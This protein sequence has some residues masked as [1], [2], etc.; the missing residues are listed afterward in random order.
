M[1]KIKG[2]NSKP[3]LMFRT[4]LWTKGIRY[5]I[6]SKNLHRKPDISIQNIY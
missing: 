6:N 4:A 1:S 5:R 2:K 3:K